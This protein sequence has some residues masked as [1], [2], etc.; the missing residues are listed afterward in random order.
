LKGS[1]AFKEIAYS[2]EGVFDRATYPNA[3]KR[4]KAIVYPFNWAERNG[5]VVRPLQDADFQ[6][7]QDLHDRW[8]ETKMADES[9]FRIMFP[10]HRYSNCLNKWKAQHTQAAASL[11]SDE[12]VGAC[13]LSDSYRCFGAFYQEKLVAFRVV[14]A[15]RKFAFDL[16]FCGLF[17]ELPSQ[18]M[19]YINTLILKLLFES[20]VEIFNCGACLNPE[21]E[22]FKTHLPSFEVNSWKYAKQADPDK[23][24]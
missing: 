17:F 14:G 24:L 7:A 6:E 10:T 5:L 18:C 3:K 22:A 16:A 21:L 13:S 20:G 4:H 8:V 2:L 11:F 19:E 15:K 9:T 1:S 12:E 23:D